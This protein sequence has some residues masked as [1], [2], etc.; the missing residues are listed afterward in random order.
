MVKRH[1]Q[2]VILFAVDYKEDKKPL[3][4]ITNSPMKKTMEVSPCAM[5]KRTLSLKKTPEQRK[6]IRR[7]QSPE[8]KNTNEESCKPS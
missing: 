5:P 4:T 3:S 1:N 6:C 8:E 2:N 7:P